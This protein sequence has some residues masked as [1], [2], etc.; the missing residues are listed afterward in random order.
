MGPPAL[1]VRSRTKRVHL[2][3]VMFMMEQEKR[4]KHSDLLF[5]CYF[6]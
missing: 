6:S 2:R 4:L 3:D 1:P 5:R